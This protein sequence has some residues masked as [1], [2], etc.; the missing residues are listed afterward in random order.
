[1]KSIE[2]LLKI[3]C[4]FWGSYRETTPFAPKSNLSGIPLSLVYPR[5]G[6]TEFSHPALIRRFDMQFGKLHGVVLVLLGLVLLIVQAFISL[7][8]RYF[9]HMPIPSLATRRQQNTSPVPGILGGASLIVGIVVFATAQRR[10]EPDSKH[11]VK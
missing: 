8:P 4:V 1:L 9:L 3:L 6:S 11:A 2:S 7:P 5:I 10:D